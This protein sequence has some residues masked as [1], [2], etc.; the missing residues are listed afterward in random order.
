MKL[1]FTYKSTRNKGDKK[2]KKIMS[3]ALS[4]AVLF[5]SMPV[6][7]GSAANV[8]ETTG[9]QLQTI[10]LDNDGKNLWVTE[11]WGGANIIPNTIWATTDMYDY[12]YNGSLSFE[13]K[14]NGQTSFPFRIGLTSHSHNEDVTIN[15]TDIEKYKNAV[16]ATP[17]WTSYT[18]PLNELAEAFSDKRFDKSNVWKISV[19]AI[20][21]GESASFR[22]VKISSDDEERQYPFIKAIPHRACAE[23]AL[24]DFSSDCIEIP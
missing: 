11:S 3:I 1:I 17:E 5:S 8:E 18:L 12:F 10:L 4:F 20:K 6:A 16:T 13:V 19:G 23:D 24:S 7:E 14:S 15:W 9:T 21:S 22:N 2:L